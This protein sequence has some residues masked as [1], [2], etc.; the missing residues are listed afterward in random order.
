MPLI[1]SSTSSYYLYI[2]LTILLLC[3]IMPSC[4]YYIEKKLI[5]IAIMAL[6]SCQPSSYTK[7]IKLNIQ[8]SCDAKSISNAKYIHLIS[9]YRRLVPY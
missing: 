3:K 6:S 7:Y 4:S 1:R 9:L 2:I 8:L 5:Y